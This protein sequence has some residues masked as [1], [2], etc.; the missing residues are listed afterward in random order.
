MQKNL[1]YHFLIF[2]NSDYPHNPPAYGAGQGIDLKMAS[3]LLGTPPL[4][5][6]LEAPASTRNSFIPRSKSAITDT[7][8][9]G[10]NLFLMKLSLP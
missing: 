8:R 10:F 9:F 7:V 5:W 3:N 1:V 6:D 4:T 2:N